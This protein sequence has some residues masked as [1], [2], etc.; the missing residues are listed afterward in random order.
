M[1]ELSG[2]E[3]VS[4][5]L[6]TANPRDLSAVCEERKTAEEA[7]RDF[8]QRHLR[9]LEGQAPAGRDLTDV[10][11]TRH[12][13]AQLRAY[14]GRMPEAVEHLAAARAIAATPGG[15][16]QFPGMAPVLEGL[17][18][19]AQLRRGE[20]E[21]CVMHPNASRCIFPITGAGRHEQ[22]A[23]A[24]AAFAAFMTALQALPDDL[25]LRWLL[26][27]T[28]MALNRYPDGVPARLLIPPARFESAENP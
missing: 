9:S 21:N 23:P 17:I 12:D 7:A 10:V 28:A 20:L 1:R 14:D 4:A 15:R 13:L 26:N 27:V 2:R 8:Q 19:V 22:T 3:Q 6:T 25:E 5:F 11:W 24:D 16:R 18:G